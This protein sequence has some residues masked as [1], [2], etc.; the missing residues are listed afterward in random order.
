MGKGWTAAVVFGWA[1]C[2]AAAPGDF[3]AGF[4]WFRACGLDRVDF[5]ASRQDIAFD[6]VVEQE[7]GRH[8]VGAVEACDGQGD[9][10]V[11]G[12]LR[13]DIDQGKQSCDARHSQ[14]CPD[15][16][17]RAWTHSREVAGH[18]KSIVSRK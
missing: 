6:A 10:V 18:G 3:A 16:H 15:R 11:E 1:G 2:L 17:F 8:Q 13:A 5:G 14:G 12:C 7:C 4:G 9:H